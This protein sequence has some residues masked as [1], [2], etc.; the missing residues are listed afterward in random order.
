MRL[1]R[2]FAGSR[3]AVGPTRQG[4][5]RRSSELSLDDLGGWDGKHARQGPTGKIICRQS[6]QA[7]KSL[8][9]EDKGTDQGSCVTSASR[10]KRCT[11]SSLVV[12]VQARSSTLTQVGFAI[13]ESST[14]PLRQNTAE[15]FVHFSTL[16]E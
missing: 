15:S 7:T 5:N 1:Q 2:R 14:Q 11:E 16:A 12:D 4:R 8:P 9:A 6:C 13:H 3:E 10:E